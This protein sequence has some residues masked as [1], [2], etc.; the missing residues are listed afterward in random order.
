MKF[1]LTDAAARRTS[2]W[3]AVGG[4]FSGYKITGYEAQA[5]TLTVE[6]EG[7]A[8]RLR[9]KVAGSAAAR[10]W[11][12]RPGIANDVTQLTEAQKLILQFEMSVKG[13]SRAEANGMWQD[14]TPRN[15]T[16]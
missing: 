7:V 15:W 8:T 4:S 3:L 14:T 10:P 1:V 2:D 5:E 11:W 9:L 6:R 16:G 13:A 12:E